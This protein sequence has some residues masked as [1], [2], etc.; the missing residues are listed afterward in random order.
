MVI[1]VPGGFGITFVCFLSV[2]VDSYYKMHRRF[3]PGYSPELPTRPIYFKFGMDQFL[4]ILSGMN[5]PGRLYSWS[6]RVP[7]TPT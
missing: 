7:G 6:S 2:Q 3:L 4:G 1:F 5:L